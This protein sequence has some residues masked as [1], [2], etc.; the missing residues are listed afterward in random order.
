[1]WRRCPLLLQAAA[2]ASTVTPSTVNPSRSSSTLSVLPRRAGPPSAP[3]PRSLRWP[4][5]SRS[6][7]GSPSCRSPCRRTPGA[8]GRRT[9]PRPRLPV[10][11]QEGQPEKAL[12]G[13]EGYGASVQHVSQFSLSEGPSGSRGHL[14]APPWFAFAGHRP[15]D[16]R[17]QELAARSGG[18][19]QASCR[20]SSAARRGLDRA[21]HHAKPACVRNADRDTRRGASSDLRTEPRETS[22]AKPEAATAPFRTRSQTK[23]TEHLGRQVA[24][25]RTA[26]VAGR[27]RLSAPR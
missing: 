2:I 13:S 9:A 10:G 25:P 5:S 24:P 23:S 21:T 27:I 20:G 8:T 15:S 19:R 7:R 4:G 12:R 17:D 18:A 14:G 3:P 6:G 11:E 1:M 16:L 22:M 26:G